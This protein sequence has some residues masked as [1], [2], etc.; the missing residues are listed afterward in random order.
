MR[1]AL[2]RTS[3]TCGSKESPPRRV[4][5]RQTSSLSIL[6][7]WLE[8]AIPDQRKKTEGKTSFSQ[9]LLRLQRPPVRF[10]N[11]ALD[12]GLRGVTSASQAVG[13]RA[14]FASGK[15]SKSL[16]GHYSPVFPEAALSC[17]VE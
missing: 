10:H 1:V 5:W 12:P 14:W 13:R 3:N 9:G 6:R 7:E 11:D 17:F 2:V 4:P 15:Q 8:G 16:L